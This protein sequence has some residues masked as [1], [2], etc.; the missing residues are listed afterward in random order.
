MPEPTTKASI[1]IMR[2]A[3][4]QMADLHSCI[5]GHWIHSHEEDAQDVMV[6]RPENYNFPPSRG[7]RGFEFREGGELVYFGIDR[8]NGAEQ[9]SGSWVIEG[10]NLVRINV[11]SDRIRPFVL[12]V[13]S[14]ND[15]ALKVS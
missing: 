4:N 5:L 2:E 13:V 12:H 15:Q 11:N 3:H 8:A 1:P 6:Y 9:F 14:C 7:R 10:S